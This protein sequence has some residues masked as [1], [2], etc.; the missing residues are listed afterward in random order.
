MALRGLRAPSTEKAA[1]EEERLPKRDGH[2]SAHGGLGNA[3][4]AGGLGCEEPVLGAGSERLRA[5]R[6][7]PL[8]QSSSR[9]FSPG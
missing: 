1:G 9:D 6:G 5:H 2:V 8:P 3:K 7:R 4:G